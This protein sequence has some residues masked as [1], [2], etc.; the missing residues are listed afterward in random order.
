MYIQGGR[1]RFGRESN[2]GKEKANIYENGGKPWKIV[3]LHENVVAMTQKRSANSSGNTLN[4]RGG[5]ARTIGGPK[6][7]E[8]T[9]HTTAT[10][11]AGLALQ[12]KAGRNKSGYALD[13]RVR[14][15]SGA[16]PAPAVGG[17]T[18]KYVQRA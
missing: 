16:L 15:C 3:E 9:D 8:W 5:L 17:I 7:A 11:V 13:D 10:T 1:P 14:A 4:D 18:T 6:F 12:Q 2:G